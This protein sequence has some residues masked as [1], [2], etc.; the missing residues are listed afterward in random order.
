MLVI[1]RY[2][3]GERQTSACGIPTEWLRAMG[4]MGSHRQTFGRL[5]VHTPFGTSVAGAALDVL[6]VRLL[7]LCASCAP[8]P[9]ATSRPPRST[10]APGTRSTPTAATSA[11]DGRRRARLAQGARQRLPAARRPALA[12]P[13]GA[14]CGGGDEMELWIDRKYV[15]A[16]YGWSFPAGDETRIGVGSFDPRF[17]VK[18]TTVMLAEDLSREPGP[19]PG[20]LDPAPAA[21]GHRRRR[22]LRGRPA[23]HCL[24]LTAEGI[25][26]ALLLRDRVRPRAARGGGGQPADRRR[27]GALRRLQR[28]PPLEVRGML[29]AQRRSRACRPRLLNRSISAMQCEALRGLGL[30]PLPGH[31]PARVRGRAPSAVVVD[32]LDVVAVGV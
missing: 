25:R 23:G 26:T 8:N 14:P 6:D 16:G 10:G 21:R 5:V 12:R 24:P 20:Q 28:I 17:H 4:L 27:A 31:S 15:P 22:L 3:I 30:R 18:D 7:H 11:P 1:D 13:R 29:L 9:T 19:L 2:E 32:E